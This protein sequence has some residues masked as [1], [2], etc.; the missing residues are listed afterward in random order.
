MFFADAV[1]FVEGTSENVLVPYFIRNTECEN[2][3]ILENNAK[4]KNKKYEESDSRYVTILPTGGS[5]SHRFK[6]LIEKLFL[7]CRCRFRKDKKSCK[8]P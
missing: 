8:S 1:I 3:D 7:I 5:H 6:P 4:C 2:S